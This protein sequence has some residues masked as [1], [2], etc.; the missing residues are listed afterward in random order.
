MYVSSLL[1]FLTSEGSCFLV[2]Q[3][4][5][6]S[7]W[8]KQS[9]HYFSRFTCPCLVWKRCCIQTKMWV[10]DSTIPL[11]IVPWMSAVL[12]LAFPW[13][14]LISYLSA[15]GFRIAMS[16]ISATFSQDG[17]Q[18][19]SASEDSNVYIWNY[20]NL[21]KNCS[22][23][24]NISSRESFL[25][26]NA[27]IAIPWCG[28]KSDPRTLMSSKSNDNVRKS[29]LTNGE[30]PLNPKVEL[31]QVAPHASPNGFSQ[32]RVLMESLTRGSATWPEETLLNTSPAAI[33]SDLWKFE[34][35][36]LKSAY[37]SMLSSHKWGLVI[38]TAGFDGRIQTYLN[39]GL[40]IRV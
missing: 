12:I 4:L 2:V 35:K 28:I 40:P 25:F 26:H 20:T 34:L 37:Q 10:F 21:E 24:K 39:Y 36:V 23:G 7:L 9:D 33:A 17:K 32:K 31:E 30:K 8:S 38:V 13:F 3:I 22:K 5:V 16:Q 1:H 14:K 11:I 19:I 18:I 27:S 29:G 15:P 6:L